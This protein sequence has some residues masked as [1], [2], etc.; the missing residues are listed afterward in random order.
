MSLRK[1]RRTQNAPM[2]DLTGAS[3][4][5]FTLLLFYILSQNF[6][7]ALEVALPQ[8][9]PSQNQNS[10]QDQIIT[11][12]KSGVIKIKDELFSVATLKNSPEK[13]LPLLQTKV[14]LTVK[15]DRSAPAESLIALMEFLANS[16]FDTVNFLGI[17]D[18]TTSQKQ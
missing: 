5:I 16:G 8:L 12:E 6:L 11:I 15:T 2:L 1:F 7:P 4:I 9:K 10:P 14:P 13:L 18:V 3:D 17:P